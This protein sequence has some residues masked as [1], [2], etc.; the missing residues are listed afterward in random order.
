MKRIFL[1]IKIP[2]SDILSG[3]YKKIQKEFINDNIKW[4]SL[5][6]LHITLLFIGD[7]E[8]NQ[9]PLII[10][11][12]SE[13]KL[14]QN[15][16][17]IKI[18][19]FGFFGTLHNPRVLWLGIDESNELIKLKNNIDNALIRLSVNLKNE[20]E[21]NPHLTI[22]RPKKI[23]D[24]NKLKQ[25]IEY[26]KGK[27]IIQFNTDHYTLFESILKPERPEYYSIKHF[28]LI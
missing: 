24:Y 18:K 20:P 15:Y 26:N 28:N 19:E 22:G 2:Q 4:V 16:I 5:N 25:L 11:Y 9:I 23:N 21:F 13:I 27:E 14:N 17:N 12:L 3:F 7:T 10:K 1:G 6:N 8:E